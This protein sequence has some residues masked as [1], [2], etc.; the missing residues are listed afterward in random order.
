MTIVTGCGCVETAAAAADV[1][2]GDG[3]YWSASAA[4][5]LAGGDTPGVPGVWSMSILKLE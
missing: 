2:D 4:A 3:Q 5:P 1:G